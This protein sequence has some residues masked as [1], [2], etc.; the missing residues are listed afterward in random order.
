M[1]LQNPQSRKRELTRT[2]VKVTFCPSLV[3]ILG[4]A[5]GDPGHHVGHQRPGEAVQGA[6]L[7]LVVR[8][9]DDQ[10]VAVLADR[11][12][13]GHPRARL[14]WG[15]FTVTECR[16]QGHRHP[17]GHGDGRTSDARHQ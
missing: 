7:A 17:G 6:V 9:L 13:G 2:N 5:L 1:P 8:P 15:P 14:P 16:R 4:E 10:D 12:G 11:D 3:T